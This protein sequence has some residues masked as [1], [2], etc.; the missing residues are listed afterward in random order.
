[1]SLN[2]MYIEDTARVV[3]SKK[4]YFIQKKAAIIS[5]ILLGVIFAGGI[6]ITY[7]STK[8][9]NETCPESIISNN[10]SNENNLNEQLCSNLFCASPLKIRGNYIFILQRSMIMVSLDFWESNAR[11]PRINHNF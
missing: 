6:I 7:F 3:K 10:S 8:N 4:G 1:M 11:L 2:N 9:R 5:L